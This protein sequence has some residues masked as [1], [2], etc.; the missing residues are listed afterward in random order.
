MRGSRFLAVLAALLLGA[1]PAEAHLLG[2]GDAGLGAGVLHPLIGL[3]HLLA[4]IAVGAWAAQIGGRTRWLVPAAFAG[5]VAVGG[6][7]GMGGTPVPGM[8]AAIALSVLL[9]GGFI[10]LALR[11]S[12]ALSMALAGGFALFHGYAHGTELPDAAAPA[13]YAA[14]FLAATL[15]L[16][17][18]GIGIGLLLPRVA[19]TLALRTGGAAVAA[20]GVLLLVGV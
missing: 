11:P 19:G 12:L 8:E 6:V 20:A 9:L 17:A 15:L 13:P 2:A 16:H 18:V 1:T 3:D 10:L 7:I 14:G 4:M 5:M